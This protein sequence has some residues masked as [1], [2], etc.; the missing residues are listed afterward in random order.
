[1]DRFLSAQEYYEKSIS[2]KSRIKDTLGLGHSLHN[3]GT[4]LLELGQPEEAMENLNRAR[5]MYKAIGADYEI[6]TVDLSIATVLYRKEKIEESLVLWESTLAR[7][8]LKLTLRDA[9]FSFLALS[10]CYNRTNQPQK[11]LEYG[12]AGL[13]YAELYENPRAIADYT[14]VIGESYNQ[15]GLSDSATIYL[16]KYAAV[17]D[18]LI[19]TEQLLKQQEVA[20]RLETRLRTAEIERQQLIIERQ[21]RQQR[22]LFGGLAMLALLAMGIFLIFRYRLR[23]QQA[24]AERQKEVADQTLREAEQ[25]AELKS[26]RSMIEGQEAERR[27]VAK[28]LHD[29]LGGLLAT[30]KAR[31]NS[32]SNTEEKTNKLIDRACTEVRRIAHNMMPQTLALSGL[33][34]SIKDLAAQLNARGLACEVEITGQPN[35]RLDESGQ[36][37]LLRIL[38]ELTHNVIKHAKAQKLFIQLLDQ[39]NQLLLTVEDDGIGFSPI[40]AARGM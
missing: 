12:T 3:L 39:P 35:L 36:S 10:D 16:S 8:D 17:I 15:L 33:S 28:D 2:L 37:M 24:E 1:M 26:L 21:N 5:A 25:K 9:V 31:V 32:S 23:Y 34:D 7:D 40:Q 13:E 6:P 19:E 11:A 20:E 14:R 38:Q 29:G 30:V 27:R 22:T 4:V 18:T